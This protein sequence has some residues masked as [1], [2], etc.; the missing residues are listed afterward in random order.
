MDRR[1]PKPL[2]KEPPTPI[3]PIKV[4]RI[5]LPT[6]E[7]QIPNLKVTKELAVIIVPAIRRIEQPRQIRLWMN[8]LRMRINKPPRPTP[9]ARKTARIV[10]DIHI[11]AILEPII[12]HKAKHVVLDVAEEM[13]VGLH[14]PVVVVVREDRMSVEEA[15]VP[16]AHVAVGD[17]PALSY[18]DGPEVFERVEEAAF[19]D[20]FGHRPVRSGDDGVVAFGGGE[21][22]GC[23]L[24]GGVSYWTLPKFDGW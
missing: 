1:I 21:V 11:K 9:Q 4:P 8:Q 23:C 12:T 6:K 13:H 22:A 24:S 18:A 14:A 10:E 20:P 16:A 15:G 17:H 2:I 5:R 7:I 19:V 3:Q